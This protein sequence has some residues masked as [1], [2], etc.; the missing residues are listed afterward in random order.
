MELRWDS[1]DT[2]DESSYVS[3]IRIILRECG[4]RIGNSL[5]EGDFSFLCDKMVHAFVPRIQETI[6]KLRR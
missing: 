1:E 5:D 6:Y 4:T 2:G 3:T